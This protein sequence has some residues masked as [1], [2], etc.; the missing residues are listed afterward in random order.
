MSAKNRGFR[1]PLPPLSAKNQKL[2]YPLSPPCQK[3]QK[4]AN[5]FDQ[6]KMEEWEAKEEREVSEGYV[7]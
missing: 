4:L 1:P 3:N 2:A 5:P 7:E 6:V